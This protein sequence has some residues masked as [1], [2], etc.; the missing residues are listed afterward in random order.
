MDATRTEAATAL[1]QLNAILARSMAVPSPMGT[2]LDKQ[3]WD[4]AKAADRYGNKDNKP[5]IELNCFM[6]RTPM[7]ATLRSP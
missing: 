4:A 7:F 1:K 6:S 5:L 2:T 3:F